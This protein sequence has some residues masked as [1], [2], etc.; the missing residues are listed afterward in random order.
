[1]SGN[2]HTVTLHTQ[3][4]TILKC[5]QLTKNNDI[6]V[7]TFIWFKLIYQKSVLMLKCNIVL[8]QLHKLH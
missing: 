8:T 1:M 4:S 7:R 2:V 3:N 6:Q 5:K